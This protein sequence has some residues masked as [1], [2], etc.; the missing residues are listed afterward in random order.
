MARVPLLRHVSSGPWIPCQCS[1]T[2]I[3]IRLVCLHQE[4]GFCCT[5]GIGIGSLCNSDIVES[6]EI[7][8]AYGGA[9]RFKSVEWYL[10]PL[11]KC[12]MHLGMWYYGG[13]RLS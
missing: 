12:L 1:T 2:V 4:L 7:S 5:I 8:P 6:K 9:V 10:H 11:S 3:S 13:K